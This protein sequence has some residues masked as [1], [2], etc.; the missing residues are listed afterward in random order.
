MAKELRVRMRQRYNESSV[1]ESI[2]PILEPGEI[3]IESNTGKFKYGD[4]RRTWKNLDYAFG[5]GL[6]LNLCTGTNDLPAAKDHPGERAIVPQLYEFPEEKD[7]EGKVV[8]KKY[9]ALIDTPYISLRKQGVWYWTIFADQ[10]DVPI[11]SSAL[12]YFQL[13]VSILG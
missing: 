4:G 11:A 2:N 10:K 9:T 13:D 7:S 1:W 3:G 5:D 12:D 6:T 8:A